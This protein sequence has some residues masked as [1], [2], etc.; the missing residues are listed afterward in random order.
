VHAI[1]SIMDFFDYSAAATGMTYRNSLNPAGVTIDGNPDTVAAGTPT[2]EQVT[3]PQGTINQVGTV[4]TTGFTP[5]AT[6]YY[7]DHATPS[8]TAETQCTGD[9]SAY[10][11]SGLYITS[12]IPNTDPATGAT[13]SLIGTRV[14]YFE[15]PGETAT[16][17]A[18][19]AGQVSS[20]LATA[21]IS[22][23]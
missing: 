18:D 23:P 6:N 11:S 7:L 13:A 19:R 15:S 1:P 21:A 5:T 14:M 16:D 4:Q 20:P 8:G 12:P 3:G 22:A 10:G 17:A 2:W 9:A